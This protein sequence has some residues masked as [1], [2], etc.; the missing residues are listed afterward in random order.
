MF[1]NLFIFYLKYFNLYKYLFTVP[2]IVEQIKWKWLN[3]IIVRI[4]WVE[5][6]NS[7]GVILGYFVS[8]TS[9][10]HI[11]PTSW[12]QL[13]VSQYQNSLDVCKIIQDI[14]A[15]MNYYV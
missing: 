9:E 4:S 2:G 13:N 5:P 7:N 11:P 15:F 6:I 3:S 12:K 8:Y 14:I 1:E 10:L